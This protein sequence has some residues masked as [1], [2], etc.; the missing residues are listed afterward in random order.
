MSTFTLKSSEPAP[1]SSELISIVTE[2][3]TNVHLDLQRAGIIPDPHIG[4]NE[5]DVQW[6]HDREWVYE[7]EVEIDEIW[8]HRLAI[9][10]ANL[11]LECE[12]LD[13][14][15]DVEIDGVCAGK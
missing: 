3:P 7:A 9:K 5:R 13:T 14:Y 6:V 12:G 2:I 11:R 1:G 10:K 15:V 4:T 8:A